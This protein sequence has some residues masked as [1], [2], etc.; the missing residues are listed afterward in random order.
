MTAQC[1][2]ALGPTGF[3]RTKVQQGLVWLG[4]ASKALRLSTTAFGAEMCGV[5]RPNQHCLHRDSVYLSR[6]EPMHCSSCSDSVM[7]EWH[8]PC[9]WPQAVPVQELRP[10]GGL[11]K[12][13]CAVSS[14]ARHSCTVKLF[15]RIVPLSASLSGPHHVAAF[16]RAQ[17]CSITTAPP[18]PTRSCY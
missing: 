7:T 15:C 14:A 13:C 1:T 4:L 16:C 8:E 9:G 6:R 18:N 12:I 2:H 10:S 11:S 3:G 5:G 17:S